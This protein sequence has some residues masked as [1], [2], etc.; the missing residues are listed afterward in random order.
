MYSKKRSGPKTEPCGTPDVTGTSG[1]HSPSSIL[2]LIHFYLSIFI[3]NKILLLYSG[4]KTSRYFSIWCQN[5]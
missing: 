3:S 1:E 5:V 4:T 2:N